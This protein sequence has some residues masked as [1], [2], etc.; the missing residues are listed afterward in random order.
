VQYFDRKAGVAV[1]AVC[2][3]LLFGCSALSYNP[4]GHSA[5]A[6]APYP[7]PPKRAEIPPPPPAA[8]L[9]WLVGHWN[10]DGVKYVWTPG[11]YVQRPTPSANWLPGYWEQ[12]STGWQW[13]EGHWES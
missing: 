7:P 11:H 3:A 9:L 4:P 12:G 5:T 1:T 6:V 10:W 13:T 2:A 8:D